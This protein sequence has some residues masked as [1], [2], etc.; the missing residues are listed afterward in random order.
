MI[1]S[2]ARALSALLL[3]ALLLGAPS[4]ACSPPS[5]SPSPAPS[6]SAARAAPPPG[7]PATPSRAAPPLA[8]LSAGA[9]PLRTRFNRDAAHPR[10]LLMLSPT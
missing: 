3:G 10:L 6:A 9:E 8:D 4:V 1:R 5:P 7:A 2:A